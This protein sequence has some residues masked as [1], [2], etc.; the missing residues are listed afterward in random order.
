MNSETRHNDRAEARR[1][2][3]K[4]ETLLE[5]CCALYGELKREEIVDGREDLGA[6]ADRLLTAMQFAL[7]AEVAA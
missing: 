1:A 2:R 4:F 5:A 6:I 3:A 7:G